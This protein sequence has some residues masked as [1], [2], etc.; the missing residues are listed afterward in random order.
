MSLEKLESIIEK[1][2]NGNTLTS[3][4]KDKSYPSLSVVYRL[5]RQDD[6]L[7]KKIM[8]A[9]EVGTFTILDKIHDELNE[10]QD[11]KYFQ[12]YREKAHHARWLASKLASGIF[13][14]KSKQEI[15]QDTNLSISWGR[16]QEAKA[17]QGE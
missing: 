15:K 9:R 1:L 12:Q 4:C 8:K 3:I 7:H 17:S 6:E 5:M 11:P 14:D 2:E 13:G 10:P 16:P